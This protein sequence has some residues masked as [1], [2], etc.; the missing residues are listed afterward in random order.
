M[1]NNGTHKT[2]PYRLRA[3][4]THNK[5]KTLCHQWVMKNHPEVAETLRRKAKRE[6]ARG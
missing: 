1:N 6:V 2:P 3:N 5:L 4:R